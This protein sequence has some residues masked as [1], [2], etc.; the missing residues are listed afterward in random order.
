M[1]EREKRSLKVVSALSVGHVITA[2]PVL[3]AA[4]HTIDFTCGDCG[5]V[6]LQA[7]PG[8]VYGVLIL[9]GNC[10]TYNSTDDA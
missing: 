3:V 9:C 1:Q 2:P 10:G 6:L 4:S 7:Q 5:T 8:Q